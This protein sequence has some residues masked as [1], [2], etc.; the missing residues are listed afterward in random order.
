M[1]EKLTP[2]QQ[3]AVS[4]RGGKLLVSAAA[5]SGKTKVLVDRLMGYLTDPVDPANIDEFLIITFTKAAAAELRGKI[6]SKLSERISQEPENRH[7]HQQL[8]RLYMTNISTVHSFCSDILHQFAHRVDLSA[9]FRVAD[10]NECSQL[11]NAAME[12]ILEEA[13]RSAADNPQFRSFVDTQGIGRNDR[14]VPLILLRVYQ[15]SRCHLDPAGW[16]NRCLETA[17]PGEAV[18]ASETL[19]GDYLMKSFFSYLEGS[20]GKL[21]EGVRYRA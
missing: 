3:E 6:A 8:Q 17:D 7:L 11:Q 18:D 12:Q 21:Q 15:S 2:Q 14:M 5:G 1:A 13:Y 10:E 19:W 9:D 16:I 20:Y 4:N